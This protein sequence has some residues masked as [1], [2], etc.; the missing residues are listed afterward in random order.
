[1]N[2]QRE[3][4]EEDRFLGKNIVSCDYYNRQETGKCKNEREECRMEGEKGENFLYILTS[5]GGGGL[6]NG[7]QRGWCEKKCVI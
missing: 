1:L 2:E 3:G 7:K 6:L 4:G 5:G